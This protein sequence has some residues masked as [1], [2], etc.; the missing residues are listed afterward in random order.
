MLKEKRWRN[1]SP[2]IL[3]DDT[4]CV[5]FFYRNR[6]NLPFTVSSHPS[7]CFPGCS[8]WFPFPVFLISP[9]VFLRAVPSSFCLNRRNP[10]RWYGFPR[11]LVSRSVLVPLQRIAHRSPALFVLTFIFIVYHAFPKTHQINGIFFIFPQDPWFCLRSLVAA[12]FPSWI[13]CF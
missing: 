5:V 13:R 6:L 10:P 8:R 9:S 4:L 11:G 12:S 1:L 2:P 3:F 7:G